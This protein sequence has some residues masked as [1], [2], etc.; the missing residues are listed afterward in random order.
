MMG[1]L[2][3]GAPVLMTMEAWWEGFA[4]PA[5]RLM[6]L[7][8]VNYGILLILQHYSGLSHRK[9]WMSQASAAFVA[10]GIGVVT[11]AIM[12]LALGVLRG[13]LYV[14]DLVGK[15]VIQSVP[16][17]IGASVAMSEFGEAHRTAEKRRQQAGM[18][19][20]IGMGIAGAALFGFGVSTVEEP[21]LIASR[22]HW[23]HAMLLVL[24]SLTQI[25]AIDYAVDFKQE[26][27]DAGTPEHRNRVLRETVL[28]Y[29]AALGIAA[30]YLWTFGTIT[31][32][33]GLSASVFT[34]V[35]TG[36][37]TSLGAAAAELLI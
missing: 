30:Y 26:H 34:I 29:V 4:V 28:T 35:T 10:Y 2:L 13:D 11:S 18:W 36:F 14:R 19:G 7:Y 16:V 17:S 23:W 8:L 3:I 1:G 5:W 25:Y 32:S 12:L 27:D 33:L 24:V 6:L 20:N 22:L 37:V 21:T 31:P 9:T 15:L